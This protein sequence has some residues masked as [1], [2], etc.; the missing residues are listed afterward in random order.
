[1]LSIASILPG[2][3]ESACLATKSRAGTRWRMALT[4]VSRSDG[5]PR[6]LTRTSRDSAVMRWATNPA[7]GE[8]R[9]YG[10]QS[11]AGNCSTTRS[12]AKKPSARARTAMRGPSR[13]TTTTLVAGA[14][15]R[16]ATA[17]ARSETTNPSAPS[18]TPASVSGRPA[19][20]SSAGVRAMLSRTL[21]PMIEITH[22]AEQRGIVVRR[23]G[24]FARDPSQQLA[25]RHLHELLEVGEFLLRQ[26]CDRGIGEAA[27]DQIHF[28]HPAMP[29]TE[30]KLAPAD[31]QSFAR[32]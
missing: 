28:P 1:M 22:P 17:R 15:A 12:G 20:R 4:V 24:G 32:T 27:H 9:S 25:V 29:G 31:I 5:R 26:L 8:T 21:A 2:V 30:Q 10:W 7:C 23:Y 16:A 14:L 19:T 11:Q 13:H 18:A 6:P 3:T